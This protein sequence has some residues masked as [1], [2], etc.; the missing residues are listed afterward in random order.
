MF[1]SG[2]AVVQ[3]QSWSDDAVCSNIVDVLQVNHPDLEDPAL[4][5]SLTPT[6]FALEASVPMA[7]AMEQLLLAER[8]GFL[9]RDDTACGLFFYRNFFPELPA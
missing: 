5:R 3:D 7:V 1:P 9:C 2:V 6:D 8:K 4:G